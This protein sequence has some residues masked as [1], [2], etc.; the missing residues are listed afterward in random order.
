LTGNIN[1]KRLPHN[2]GRI[3]SIIGLTLVL[4]VM[5]GF[6]L[7]T[8]KDVRWGGGFW[9]TWLRVHWR[10]TPAVA[11]QA[12]FW[13]RKTI[14]FLGYGSLALLFW[15]YFYLWGLRRTTPLLGLTTTALVAVVDEYNQALSNFRTGNPNDVLLDCCGGVVFVLVVYWVLQRGRDDGRH[16]VNR[17]SN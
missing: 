3:W 17:G 15:W 7:E 13:L 5:I 14:H 6:L 4:T 8:S 2:T 1:M 16:R 12:V 11:H 9:E 10:L